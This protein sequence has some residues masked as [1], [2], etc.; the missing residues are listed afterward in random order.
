MREAL[1][2][3]TARAKAYLDGGQVVTRERAT[4]AAFAAGFFDAEGQWAREKRRRGHRL[5]SDQGERHARSFKNHL[6]PF[7]RNPRIARS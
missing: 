1:I 6:E 3:A 7:L 4:F 2:R 5:S